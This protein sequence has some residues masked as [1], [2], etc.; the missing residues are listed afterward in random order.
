M[1]SLVTVA[2][3]PCLPPPGLHTP[4]HRL[5]ALGAGHQPLQ[6]P[7]P[8]PL[9]LQLPHRPQQLLPQLHQ[10][11]LQPLDLSTGGGLNIIVKFVS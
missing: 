11:L 4:D 5:S 1:R 6:G 7:R 9:L 8:V 3:A 2:G 10:L